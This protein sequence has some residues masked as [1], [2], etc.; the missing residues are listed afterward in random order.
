MRTYIN[1]VAVHLM[2]FGSPF[3]DEL[4]SLM[5]PPPS[6]PKKSAKPKRPIPGGKKSMKAKMR[7]KK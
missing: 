2:F 1:V 4:E 3:G 5:G 7:P 6:A